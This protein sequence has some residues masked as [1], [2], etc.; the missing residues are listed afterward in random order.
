M[1]EIILLIV[2]TG[3]IDSSAGLTAPSRRLRS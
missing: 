1:F 2:T 3:G